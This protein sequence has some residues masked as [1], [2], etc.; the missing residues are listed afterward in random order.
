MRA[1]SKGPLGSSSSSGSPRLW[2]PPVNV[3][4]GEAAAQVR[5]RPK[6]A[7]MLPGQG[8]VLKM[9]SGPSLPRS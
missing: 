9:L 6:R 2:G 5:L 4:G 8:G 7:T 1:A 3:A